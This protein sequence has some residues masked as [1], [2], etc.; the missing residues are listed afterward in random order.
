MSE[1]IFPDLS[2][3]KDTAK[4]PDVTAADDEVSTGADEKT[5]AALKIL[6]GGE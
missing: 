6:M 5:H 4:G 2:K 1:Y 3:T